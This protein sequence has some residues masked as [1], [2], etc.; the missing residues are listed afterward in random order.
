MFLE[1]YRLVEAMVKMRMEELLATWRDGGEG[2][3]PLF[4][5]GPQWTIERA[6][7]G[8]QGMP[9]PAPPHGAPANQQQGYYNAPQ[10][11]G[12]SSPPAQVS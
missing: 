11:Q 3:R 6:L 10:P 7:F 5:E 8:S 4:G 12:A 1:T 9:A 2:G